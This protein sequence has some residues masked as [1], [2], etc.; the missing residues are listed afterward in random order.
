MKKTNVI[1]TY[2]LAI[3][4]IVAVVVLTVALVNNREKEVVPENLDLTLLSESIDE[5]T[6]L[7][8]ANLQP[9]T[10]D[11]LKEKFQIDESWVKNFIGKIPSVNISSSMYIIIEATDGNVENIKQAFRTYGDSYEKLWSDYLAEEYELVQNRKIGSKGNYVYFIVDVYAEDV[12]EL[13]K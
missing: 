6:D 3:F 1:L 5:A 8:G 2:V 10:I 7:D 4:V 12:I 13:I 11:D 9:V